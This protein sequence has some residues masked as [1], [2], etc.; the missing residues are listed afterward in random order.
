MRK[1]SRLD[2]NSARFYASCVYSALAY[3]HS[4]K[5]VYRDLKQENVVLA[6]NGYAKLVDFGFAKSLLNA[7]RTW[8][9]CGTPQYLAPEIITSQVS[10]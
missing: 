2:E 6:A 10:F 1:R 5:I 7:N 4:R 3:L 8:T 9:L